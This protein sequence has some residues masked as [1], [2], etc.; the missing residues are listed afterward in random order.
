MF[1]PVLCLA[2]ACAPAFA[3][4]SGDL[5]DST[6]EMRR[7]IGRYATDRASLRRRYR[8]PM[9]P[10]RSER[11]RHFYTAWLHSIEQL[12]FKKLSPEGRID[13]ILFRNQLKY[14]LRSLE[15]ATK[16][17]RETHDL[18]P[19]WKTI[20]DLAEA[21]R[22]AD[23]VDPKAAAEQL[24]ALRE[25][26]DGVRAK[27]KNPT[28]ANRAAARIDALLRG[29]RSWHAYYDGYDPLFSWWTK[30]PFEAA[31][32]ALKA[33]AGRLKKQ[34]T[35]GRDGTLIGDPIGRAA[36]LSDL[37]YEM[38][39]YTPEE[40][41]E[42]AHAEFKWC[43]TE[44]DKA[45]KALG[46]KDWRKAQEHVK[47]LHVEPG[48]Q[49]ELIRDLALEAV[50]FIDKH[51]LVTVPKLCRE[52]WRME[53]MS[54]ARQ[55]TSP[56]FLGGEVVWVSFPTHTMS[57]SDKLMSLRGNNRHFS[58]AVVHHELIPG[59]HL[60]GFMTARHRS[61]RGIFRTPF[62]VEGWALYWEML[63]WD[64]DF[65]RS[66]EDRIGML[67]WRKHRCARIIFSLNF[68]LE[69][70]TA[71][72]AIDFLVERVGHERNNATA[73][74]RRSV[75]GAYGPLYQAAYMLGGLQM[76]ALRRELVD[77]K[78][79]TNREFHDAVLKQNSIP[80]EMIRA[81]LTGQ[82]LKGDFKTSWRFYP[83]SR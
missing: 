16:R 47:S 73:E 1:R 72:E 58:R 33:Y 60:Q 70:M 37:E 4:S 27:A 74:V 35:A 63:L 57:H 81:A 69:K 79:M 13:W 38:I 62:W 77:T 48:K 6:S 23:P 51:D 36:L 83:S 50:R 44:M 7:L 78:K 64:L 49:P 55:R 82:K 32:K 59:H 14:R 3:Q 42:I 25:A 40:L 21:R 46:H 5:D 28:V 15:H 8:V 18:V 20:V 76:R 45:A 12:D 34:A 17:D 66:P 68:H 22:A 41:I 39:P 11:M 67:F 53:M 9:S 54:P 43:D 52:I 30:K 80:F 31:A 24:V 29:L 71:P 2:V 75:G 19:F 56:Y 10:L 65:P 61:H 26:V